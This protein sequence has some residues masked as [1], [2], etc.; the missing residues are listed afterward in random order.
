MIPRQLEKQRFILT[1][2]AINEKAPIEK[3]WQ[4]DNNYML[5][6]IR[7]QEHLAKGGTY[8]VLTGINNL[9]VIDF[10]NEQVQNEVIEKFPETFTIKTAGKGLLHLYFYTDNTKSWKIV[11]ATKETLADIQGEGIVG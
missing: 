7:F 2:S 3:E 6:D 10:D 9:I 1:G 8:G 5:Q 4:K 11:S